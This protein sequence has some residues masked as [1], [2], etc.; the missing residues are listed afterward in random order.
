MII[1]VAKHSREYKISQKNKIPT[2]IKN[3]KSEGQLVNSHKF[4]DEKKAPQKI[5]A[6]ENVLKYPLTEEDT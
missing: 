6:K 5:V 2:L 4:T 1:V 3:I